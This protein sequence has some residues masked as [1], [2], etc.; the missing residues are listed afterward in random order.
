MG[1]LPV[2]SLNTPDSSPV[3]V[4]KSLSS[5]SSR[6]WVPCTSLMSSSPVSESG[7]EG[8]CVGG[9]LLPLTPTLPSVSS[10]F[11]HSRLHLTTRR[12]SNTHL[13]SSFAPYIPLPI[14]GCSG[15]TP[16]ASPLA[17]SLGP[18]LL[19]LASLVVC[20]PSVLSG[21]LW[22]TVMSR[23]HQWAGELCEIT[24]FI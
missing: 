3:G 15:Q 18:W 8:V 6:R 13:L 21:L 12:P 24:L 16:C 14:L 5:W 1:S 9:A 17:P 10:C 11:P 2:C 23:F 22:L 19:T 4:L 20:F 7:E